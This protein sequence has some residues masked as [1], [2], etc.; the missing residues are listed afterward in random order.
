MNHIHKLNI[1]IARLKGELQ[2]YEDG[3][4]D[5]RIYLNSSKFSVDTTVQCADVIMRLQEVR[6][7]SINKGDESALAKREEIESNISVSK[8]YKDGYDAYYKGENKLDNPFRYGPGFEGLESRNHASWNVG[9][10]A[11]KTKNTIDY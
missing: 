10:D 6:S 5:L 4:N 7:Y 2:A 1:E 11:A 9:F 8:A 3:I